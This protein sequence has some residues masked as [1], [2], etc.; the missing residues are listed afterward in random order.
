MTTYERRISRVEKYADRPGMTFAAMTDEQLNERIDELLAKLG[1]TQ[2]AVIAKYGS[3]MAFAL[4]GSP[5]GNEQVGSELV[6]GNSA[7]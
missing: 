5:E 1:T 4:K 6:P 7:P 2:E 3:L